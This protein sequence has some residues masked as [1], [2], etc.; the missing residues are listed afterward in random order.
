M[1]SKGI[2]WVSDQL[3]QIYKAGNI[4]DILMLT[5]GLSIHENKYE[6][7]VDKIKR[8]FNCKCPEGAVK[9]ECA[10][11]PKSYNYNNIANLTKKNDNLT[12]KNDNLVEGFENKVIEKYD[13]SKVR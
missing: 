5:K 2:E 4:P 1:S 10:N 6:L 9:N 12:K 7:L 8:L 13:N 3:C 11:E